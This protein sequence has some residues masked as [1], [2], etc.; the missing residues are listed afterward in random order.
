MQESVAFFGFQILQ[1]RSN[2]FFEW[3]FQNTQ[4]KIIMNTQNDGLKKCIS[5]QKS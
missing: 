4:V 5:F 2:L 3:S 1:A